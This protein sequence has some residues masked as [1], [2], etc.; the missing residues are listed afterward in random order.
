MRIAHFGTFDVEN[1]GD[2]LFPLVLERRLAG[3]GHAIVHVSP[4]GGGPVWRHCVET[5]SVD[6]AMAQRFDA[7]VIG[8]GHTIHGQPS[9]VAAYR[10]AGDRGLL[11]YSD[12]WLRSTLLACEQALPLVWNAPGVPGPFPS[13]TAVLVRWAAEQ[14]DRIALRDGTSL[15]FLRGAG[16]TGEATVALDTAIDVDALWSPA[17]LDAAWREVFRARGLAVPERAIALHFNARFLQAG[18]EEVAARLDALGLR[19]GS[20]PVLLALGPCHG[21]VELVRAI[22]SAMTTPHAA[23]GPVEDLVELVACLRGASL[24]VG[25]SLHGGVTARAFD[26]P[27]IL[28]A[29][30]APGAASKRRSFLALHGRVFE[31]AAGRRSAHVER[32]EEAWDCV[33]AILAPASGRVA[34][35]AS[36]RAFDGGGSAVSSEPAGRRDPNAAHWQGL[37][38]ALE[39]PADALPGRR[40]AGRVELEALLGDR[41]RRE[42]ISIGILLDQAREAATHRA[43]AQ[44]NAQRFRALAR[45]QRDLATDARATQGKHAKAAGERATMDAGTGAPATTAASAMK[46][47]GSGS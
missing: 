41:W 11:A 43:A 30:E 38:A 20:M 22:S 13:E 24:Y 15:G 18:V 29:P 47:D 12:L 9:D 23:I 40:R 2:L 19:S 39:H 34:S 6:D 26:R 21:D 25:S 10:A 27:A 32:W 16:F 42:R 28:V 8:G 5:I 1:Y 46:P 36:R 7:I 44:R 45:R 3:R 33:E 14:A 4:V 31:T 17:E 37:I 35:P